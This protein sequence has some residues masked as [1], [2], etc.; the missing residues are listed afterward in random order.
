VQVFD[1]D[2]QLNAGVPQIVPIGAN[3]YRP[4]LDNRMFGQWY[5]WPYGN[6]NNRS[7]YGVW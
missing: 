5:D 6:G 3:V 2:P 4:S 7:F 1:L